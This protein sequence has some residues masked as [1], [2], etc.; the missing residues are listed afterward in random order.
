MAI[1]YKRN[2]GTDLSLATS[3][4][5]TSATGAAAAAIPGSGDTVQFDA[6]SLGGTLTNALTCAGIAFNSATTSVTLSGTVTLGTGGWTNAVTNNLTTTISGTLAVGTNNQ[7]WTL[8]RTT[9]NNHALAIS[10]GFTG[11]AIITLATPGANKG[12]VSSLST[13]STFSGT[14]ILGNDTVFNTTSASGSGSGSGLS[15][16][17]TIQ[18][19]G[20]GAGVSSSAGA[21]TI[22]TPIIANNSWSIG[23]GTILQAV[24]VT[25][26]TT[27]G[28]GGAYTLT[29]L[30]AGTLTGA[31][32]M[33][34]N[35]HA[36]TATAACTVVGA[37]TLANSPYSNVLSGAAGALTISGPTTCGSG[38][39]TVRA[40]GAGNVSISNTF[41]CGTGNH[42]FQTLSGA[43]TLTISNTLTMGGG[44]HTFDA[45]SATITVSGAMTGTNGFTKTG[46]NDLIITNTGGSPSL[47]GTVT[48][49]A[50]ELYLGTSSQTGD[51]LTGITLFDVAS[52]AANLVVRSSTAFT[53][54][55]P[56]QG[57]GN[58]L[59]LC[60][61]ASG[62]TIPDGTMADMNSSSAAIGSGVYAN[63][64]AS[65]LNLSDFPAK[66]AWYL[67]GA[68]PTG[69][70]YYIKSAA[71]DHTGT[72]NL[73]TSLTV[74][75]TTT[76]AL[77]NNNA[78]TSN[79]LVL[80]GAT[81]VAGTGSVVWTL[82]GSNDGA[83]TV[84][85]VVSNGTGTLGITK[86]DGGTW[87]LSGANSYTGAVTL[88]AGTLVLAQ[89]GTTTGALGGSTSSAAITL[90]SGTLKIDAYGTNS[91][92]RASSTLALS[93]ALLQ[94]YAGSNTL[95]TG[96]VTL[97][98]AT[99][100]Q[101]DQDS[102]TLTA[103]IGGAS[104]N[105]LTKTGASGL[106]LTNTGSGYLGT[107][108]INAGD[109]YIA[110]MSSAGVASSLGAPSSAATAHYINMS[111]NTSLRHIGTTVDTN[112]DRPL[113]PV[114]SN[115]TIAVFGDGTGNGSLTLG[116]T[117]ITTSST[118]DR[119]F[120]FCGDSANTQVYS[121]PF[122]AP[123]TGTVAIKKEGTTRWNFT[124]STFAPSAIDCLDG[125]LGLGSANRTV[126]GTVGI[127]FDSEVE[128]LAPYTLDS[129]AISIGSGGT[130]TAELV[131]AS[132]TIAVQSSCTSVSPARIVAT[133]TTTGSNS[134]AGNAT[135]DGVVDAHTP[136]AVQVS[137]AG[138]GRV[139]GSG[140]VTVSSTGTIRTKA[141]V[142][143]AQRGQCRYA[144]L[145]LNSGSTLKIGYAA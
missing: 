49:S 126:S 124:H 8:Y 23:V 35:N 133:N 145:T 24:N 142:S 112:S 9:A 136:S 114:G 21:G 111:H 106:Y 70:I 130:I 91:F 69:N 25:G 61:N 89:G 66:L 3:W 43:G 62:I 74:S 19:D 4:S 127:F 52:T 32:S 53:F 13:T 71:T 101:V 139:F 107:T 50:G 5:D 117:W 90:T 30:A 110:K 27:F 33:T 76:A 102:L 93:G 104:A 137:S 128:L 100:I 99:T 6:A 64:A 116:S 40:N 17:A 109:V 73:D 88:T 31:V 84:S 96:A 92:N 87:I 12:F 37:L 16:A 143:S 108:N 113:V 22:V 41:D 82:R 26:T 60:T 129:S 135:I 86:N 132:Q 123:P 14:L 134:N 55:N 72:N 131:G 34:G 98:A 1:K 68:S 44:G 83:N 47:T 65:Y 29:T 105:S 85:G 36:I 67:Q 15:T 95:T 59:F 57:S 115:P 80:S 79:Y 121:G 58:A 141:I 45:S 138:N 46:A 94:N 81:S 97:N 7:T 103:A 10:G 120:R 125:V 63:A 42:T 75:G 140:T 2:S 144:N 28:S 51:V 77:Y 54:D 18:I 38:S 78:S 56:F 20:S 119:L 11:S 118:G 48:V 39:H 122:G